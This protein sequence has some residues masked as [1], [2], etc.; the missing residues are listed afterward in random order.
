MFGLLMNNLTEGEDTTAS[1]NKFQEL[2]SRCG[3]LYAAGIFVRSQL[4]HKPDRSFEM[5][6]YSG[7]EK[8]TYNKYQIISWFSTH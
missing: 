2:M 3:N 4:F 5:F 1:G 6:R 8:K 7:D